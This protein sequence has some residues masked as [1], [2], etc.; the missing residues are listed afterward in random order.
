MG[1]R[2]MM[3]CGAG[4]VGRRRVVEQWEVAIDAEQGMEELEGEE[5]MQNSWSLPLMRIAEQ[6]MEEL[7]FDRRRMHEVK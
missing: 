6:G 3:I 7:E 5:E 4:D 1:C 2:E